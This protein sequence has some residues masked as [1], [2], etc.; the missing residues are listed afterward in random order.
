MPLAKVS[1]M[2]TSEFNMAEMY[3]PSI[4]RNVTSH[5]LG[6]QGGKEV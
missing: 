4:E 6:H 3:S 5:G 2:V 1:H